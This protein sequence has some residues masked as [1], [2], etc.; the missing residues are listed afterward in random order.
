MATFNQ[1]KEVK[2]KHST[3]LLIQ[4]GVC[5]LDIQAD[6]NGRA[7]ICIHLD[8]RDPLVVAALP[9]ELDGIPVK[10]F[11]TGPFKKGSATG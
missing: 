9:S 6:A 10:C 8:S 7:T 4:E 3:A 2:R 5:G 1:A 11:Q